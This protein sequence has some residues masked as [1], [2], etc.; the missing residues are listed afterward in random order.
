MGE[1][2]WAGINSLALEFRLLPWL[3]GDGDNCQL[4][5]VGIGKGNL[6]EA[7]TCTKTS[8]N[9]VEVEFDDV[10]HCAKASTVGVDD[11]KLTE[12]PPTP[13]PV[14]ELMQLVI[15]YVLGLT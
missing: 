12:S 14:K 11:M 6:T 8:F 4:A 2:Y 1:I 13:K 9:F 3:I 15:W 5:T 10:V 7:Y